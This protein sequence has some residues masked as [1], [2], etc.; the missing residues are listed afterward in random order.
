[1]KKIFCLLLVLMMITLAVVSCDTNDE[2]PFD[3][4]K[5]TVTTEEVTTEDVTTEEATSEEVTTEEA[6][7]EE[8]T[9]EEPSTLGTSLRL[10]SNNI[11]MFSYGGGG[12]SR[13]GGLVA[14]FEKYDADIYNLQEVDAGWRT[15]DM[16]F[17]A[18]ERMGYTLIDTT[19]APKLYNCPIFYKTE[20]F[21]LIAS[22]NALFNTNNVDVRAYSWVCLEVKETGKRLIVLNTHLLAKEGETQVAHRLTCAQQLVTIA[23]KLMKQYNAN[24]VVLSGDYNCNMSSSAYGALADAFNSAREVCPSRVNMEYKT[25]CGFKKAPEVAEGEAIDHVFYSKTGIDAKHFEAIVEEYSYAYSDHVPVVF[26][27]ELN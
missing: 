25:S 22:S 12:A 1:M 7:T 24:G 11:A 19:D 5:D 23:E 4:V 14:A 27:F 20:K 2:V 18:M 26:D 6:T 9:T 15:D 13:L 21:N 3:D 10:V 8:V 16:L 17:G